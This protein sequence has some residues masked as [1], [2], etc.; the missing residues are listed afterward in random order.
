[1]KLIER[2]ELDAESVNAESELGAVNICAGA[3]AAG[4][5]TF[6]CTCAQGIALAKEVLWMASGMALPMVVADTSRAIGSPPTF[7]AAFSHRLS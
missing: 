3:A 4:C 1:M 7:A 6:T 5:R 2:G